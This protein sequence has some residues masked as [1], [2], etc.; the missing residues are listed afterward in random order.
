MVKYILVR[1]A[2][3]SLTVSAPLLFSLFTPTISALMA[4]MAYSGDI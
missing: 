3:L 1:D 4:V 2:L